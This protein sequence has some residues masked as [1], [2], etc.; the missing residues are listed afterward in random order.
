M[1]L[2]TGDRRIS[3]MSIFVSEKIHGWALLFLLDF[4]KVEMIFLSVRES[5]IKKINIFGIPHVNG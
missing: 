4:G 1:F 3:A 5:W 2:H